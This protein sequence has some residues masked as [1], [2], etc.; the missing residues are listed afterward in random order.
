MNRA[1]TLPASVERN[2][3]TQI[4]GILYANA[5]DGYIG[6]M[7]NVILVGFVLY[8]IS[9]TLGLAIWITAGVILNIL[10]LL[11]S[12]VYFRNPNARAPSD[13][14][15][16]QRVLTFLAGLLYGAL[17]FFLFEPEN[18]EY[19]SL[20]VFLVGGMGAA[21]VGT[22][23]IDLITYRLFLFSALFPLIIRAFY[24]QTEVYIT[25]GIMLITLV[26]VMHRA[27]KQTNKAM[28][29]NVEMS[30]SLQ[31]RATHDGLVDLLN[32]EEFLKRFEEERSRLSKSGEAMS[33]VFIDLDNFKKLNDTYGHQAGDKALIEIGNIVRA[34]IRKEDIAA[35][36]GGDE[37]MVFLRSNNHS[38]AE[39]L[40]T[41]ILKGIQLYQ[42]S[43][44]EQESGLGASIGI[45]YS[46]NPTIKFDDLLRAADKACYEAK[47][48]GKGRISILS[49]D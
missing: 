9:P 35:R 7:F 23:A 3:E 22:Y 11:Q 43:L 46:S 2:K 32:K 29:E 31:Y 21:A 14:I 49:A 24:E 16:I 15:N 30:L 37:F 10:R 8:R 26:L 1:P 18:P 47:N 39:S 40:A 19:Q 41:H 13:W 28:I 34:S 48:Q 17:A 6:S 36:F 12:K 5:R 20:V 44:N 33:I 4:A 45:G 25:L 27:A 42:G 38:A